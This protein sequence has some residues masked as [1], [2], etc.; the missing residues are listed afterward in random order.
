LYQLLLFFGR[1]PVAHARSCAAEKL[2]GYGTIGA[3]NPARK[4]IIGERFKA[5]P[6]PG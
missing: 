6:E 5:V 3:L 1:Q 4:N 2:P